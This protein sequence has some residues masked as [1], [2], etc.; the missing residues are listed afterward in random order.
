MTPP[1]QK[2]RLEYRDEVIVAQAEA[3]FQSLFEKATVLWRKRI[4]Q[5]EEL[6]HK[7]SLVMFVPNEI[8]CPRCAPVEERFEAHATSKDWLEQA[9]NYWRDGP[10]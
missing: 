4:P 1:G 5:I 6:Y 9:G 10:I 7:A 2:A 8:D 3:G